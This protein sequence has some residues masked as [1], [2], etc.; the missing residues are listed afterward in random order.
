M[1]QKRN[2]DFRRFIF[3]DILPSSVSLIDILE[4]CDGLLKGTGNL[5]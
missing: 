1:T 4:T 3:A 5:T 2:V